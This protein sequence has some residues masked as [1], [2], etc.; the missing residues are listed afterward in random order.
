MDNKLLVTSTPHIRSQDSIERIM[1]LVVIALLP[2]TFGGIYFFGVRALLIIVLSIASCV[3]FE[4]MFQKITKQETTIDDYSAVVTGLLLAMNLPPATPFYVPIL[5]GFVAIVLVKQLYGGLGQNFMNPALAARAFLFISFGKKMSAW[6]A[7][8]SGFFNLN[9]DTMTS[10][11]PLVV[12]REA[13]FIPTSTDYINAFI[14]NIGGC[15]G[16]TSALLLIL[17]GL[18][19][20]YK[21]VISYVIPLTYIGTVFVL[22]YI[23]GQNGTY[24]ILIGGL[25]LG[26]FFMATDYASSPTT[27]LG[28]VIMGLGCGVLTAVLRKYA[29]YPEIVSFAILLMNLVVPLID[30]ATKPRVFGRV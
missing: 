4:A 11:T 10:A 16:E 17:G 13:G 23:F 6:I 20:I 7:P 22:S 5:G 19:L 8:N 14:G 18:F 27:P 28:Q 12:A 2:A 9:V 30:R 29:S 25:M 1:K 21:K 24:Q 26:A 3:F 15:I